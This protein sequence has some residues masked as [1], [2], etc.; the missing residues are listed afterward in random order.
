MVLGALLKQLTM[1][2][3]S[4]C[5]IIFDLLNSGVDLS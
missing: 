3:H 5:S 1:T 4:H 2:L